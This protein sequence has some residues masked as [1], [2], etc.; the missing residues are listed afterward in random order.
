MSK[1]ERRNELDDP[2]GSVEL[3]GWRGLLWSKCK[4]RGRPK[5][6]AIRGESDVVAGEIAYRPITNK[7]N[8]A[9]RLR[10]VPEGATILSQNK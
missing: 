4:V 1:E 6:N 10:G 3:F 8:R 5:E 7:S 9:T 2:S